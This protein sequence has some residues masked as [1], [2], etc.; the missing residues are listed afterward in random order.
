[1]AKLLTL[2]ETAAK[3]RKTEQQF[4]WMLYTGSAPRS[5]KIGGR[6]MFREADVDEW[7]EAA[8]AAAGTEA[9]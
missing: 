7:V 6:L 8:F 5:A 2:P 3:L 1:M 4:R 9:G